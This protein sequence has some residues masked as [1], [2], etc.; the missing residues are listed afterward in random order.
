MRY[1]PL[2]TVSEVIVVAA[3]VYLVLGLLVGPAWLFLRAGK[4]DPA[5]AGSGRSVRLLLLPGAVAVWPVLV[6]GGGKRGGS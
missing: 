5:L 2:V 6:L 4:R 1:R 3:G